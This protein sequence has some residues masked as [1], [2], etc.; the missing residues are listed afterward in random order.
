MLY[1]ICRS[2]PNSFVIP[3]V[4]N[5]RLFDSTRYVR[6]KLTS[7]EKKSRWDLLIEHDVGVQIDM[8]Y[9]DAYA[10]MGRDESQLHR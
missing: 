4:K 7:F 8:I 6:Y 9:P 5:G 1:Q 2:I 10:A 3:P